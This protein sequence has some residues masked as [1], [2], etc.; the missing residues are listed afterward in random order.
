MTTQE[1]LDKVKENQQ[2]ILAKIN[3][4]DRERQDLLQEILRCDGA[5]REL[6]SILNE[7]K[8]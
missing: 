7:G 8:K 3:N 4:L 2:K 5:I 6:V 1:R